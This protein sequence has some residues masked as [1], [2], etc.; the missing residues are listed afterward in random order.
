MVEYNGRI[1]I[2]LSEPIISRKTLEVILKNEFQT[3]LAYFYNNY[4]EKILPK[5][6]FAV[7]AFKDGQGHTRPL[8]D[9]IEVDVWMSE[10]ENAFL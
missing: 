1:E 6:R 8:F 10:E 5:L 9:I 2:Y 4:M 7:T 3:D